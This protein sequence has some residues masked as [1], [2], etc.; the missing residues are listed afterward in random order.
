[1]L[2][3]LGAGHIAVPLAHL[4]KRTGFRVEVAD[5]RVQ[6]ANA[7]RFPDADRI[8][9]DDF[10]SAA[11]QL[12]LGPNT[13]GVVVTRGHRGDADALTTLVGRNLRYV[14]LLGSKVKAVHVLSLLRQRGVLAEQLAAVHT[15]V[16]LDIG[17]EGPEEIAVS[18]LAEMIAV[19][20][21]IDPAH[22]R[23]L[24]MDLPAGLLGR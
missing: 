16:G 24:K 8:V 18:I 21:G 11:A 6:F 22:C 14:G 12:T 15:P 7:E 2:C 4:A 9:V 13:Y 5:D 20:R 10:Q 3:I 23:S 1:V 17:A 19:R